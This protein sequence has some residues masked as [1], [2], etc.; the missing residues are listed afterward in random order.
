MFI[1]HEERKQSSTQLGTVSCGYSHGDN[2]YTIPMDVIPEE[3]RE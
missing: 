3:E 2:K 1:D